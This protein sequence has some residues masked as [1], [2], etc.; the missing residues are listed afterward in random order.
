M[1]L[2]EK[3][4]L[5][6]FCFA[7]WVWATY[8]LKRQNFDWYVRTFFPD[9]SWPGTDYGLYRSVFY[10]LFLVLLMAVLSGIWLG[11]AQTPPPPPTRPS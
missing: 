5:S 11:G 3:I 7:F 6:L 10:P 4:L 1:D 9:K 8:I 2:N